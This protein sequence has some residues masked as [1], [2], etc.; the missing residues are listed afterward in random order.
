M[1]V[2]RFWLEDHV[3]PPLTTPQLVERLDLTGTKVE[4]VYRHGVGSP[5]RFVVGRVLEAQPHPDAD[6]LRVCTVD[7]GDGAPNQIVCG[8]PNVAKPA[9]RSRS[10]CP[11]R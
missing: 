11:A 3:R 8:A 4:R 2:P 7:V 6:R 10:R 9:R 1:L 5:E